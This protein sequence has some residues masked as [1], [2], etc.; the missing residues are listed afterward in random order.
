M[1][2]SPGDFGTPDIEGR[3]AVH[4]VSLTMGCSAVIEV[5]KSA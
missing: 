2:M 1:V 3:V 5:I 4:D